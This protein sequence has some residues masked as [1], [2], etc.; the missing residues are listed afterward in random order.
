M[1]LGLKI[2]TH[3]KLITGDKIFIS[4]K[5]FDEKVWQRLN[6]QQDK[7]VQGK[8]EVDQRQSNPSWREEFEGKEHRPTSQI[9]TLSPF[10]DHQT[11]PKGLY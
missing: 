11:L 3:I 10:Q 4:V 7:E 8:E 2:R 9:T 6:K 1:R 5:D